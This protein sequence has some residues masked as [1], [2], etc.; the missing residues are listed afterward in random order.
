M[1]NLG[2]VCADAS[3]GR[4]RVVVGR[5]AARGGAGVARRSGA[6]GRAALR[7]GA[8][9][10]DRAALGAGAGAGGGGAVC[11]SRPAVVGDGDLRALDGDQASV[12]VGVRDVDARGVGL[13]PSAALLP[14]GPERAGAGRVDGA[15]AH[16]PGRRGSGA[17]ADAGGDSEGEAGEALSPAG[18]ADRLD[19]G[20][21]RHSVSDRRGVGGRRG[22]GAGPGGPQAGGQDRRRAHRSEGSLARGRQAPAG[23]HAHGAPPLRA[24][25]AGGAQAHRANGSAARRVAQGGAAAGGRG[26][27]AGARARRPGPSSRQRA[28]SRS[29]PTAARRCSSRSTSG[30]R[31]RRSASG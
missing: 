20:R 31:A 9:G 1:T 18:S 25:Q 4:C 6:V 8:A 21:G 29:S 17:P 27:A 14:A 15:Q 7:S 2:G 23:D 3:R 10:A 11:R 5:A 30:S 13:D 22:Q 16:A 12:R 19:R 24:G 28:S 26:A